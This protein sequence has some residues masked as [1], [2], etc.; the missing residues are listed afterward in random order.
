[1]YIQI[2]FLEAHLNLNVFPE[3]LL[4][5]SGPFLWLISLALFACLLGDPL[6]T[7]TNLELQQKIQEDT[8]LHN[9]MTDPWDR[10]IYVHMVD[11]LW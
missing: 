2:G 6:A 10:Y 9:P 7:P 1:M 8:E 4:M 5:A 3:A 11:F